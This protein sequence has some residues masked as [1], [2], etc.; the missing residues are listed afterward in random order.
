[1][2]P[3][4]HKVAVRGRRATASL[5]VTPH[6]CVAAAADRVQRLS[7]ADTSIP[8]AVGAGWG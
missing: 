7:S 4:Q 3:R 6:Q 8:P 2:L 5:E 1:M